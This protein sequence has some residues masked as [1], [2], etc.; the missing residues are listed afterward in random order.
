MTIGNLLCLA[1]LLFCCKDNF[2]VVFWRMIYN[3]CIF[4]YLKY[5][6]ICY[7]K[8][9]TAF[10]KKSVCYCT[11]VS[12]GPLLTSPFAYVLYIK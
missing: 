1:S 10:T 11:K 4:S 9:Y 5:A 8:F 6:L 12:I 2:I 3:L 7:Y